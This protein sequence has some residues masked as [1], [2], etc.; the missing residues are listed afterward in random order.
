M[1]G[2]CCAVGCNN[3]RQRNP[4]LQFHSVPKELDRRNK[5]LASIRRDRWQPTSNSILCC[6][7][8][9]GRKNDNPMSP[10]YVPSLFAHTSAGQRQKNIYANSMFEHT[11]QMKW[12]KTETLA[13]CS[14]TDHEIVA[15]F[16]TSDD[17]D[18]TI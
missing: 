14:D 3:S 2:I 7:H 4:R 6:Q 13:P 1:P 10:D 16:S 12:K 9:T 17:T 11:Q 18:N 5:W 15:P 8:F